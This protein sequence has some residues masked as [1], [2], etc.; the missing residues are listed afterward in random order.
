LVLNMADLGVC[1]IT[2]AARG[3]GAATARAAA[4]RGF[5]V[6]VNYRSAQS[7]AAAVVADIRQAGG[8]AHAFEADIR[9]EDDVARLFAAVDRAFGPVT[10]LVN[11]A[12]ISGV[13][14]AL[15]DTDPAVMRVVIETNLAGTLFCTR[16]AATRMARS[17]G[18][19]GGA[20]VSLSSIVTRTGG[21]RLATY[22]AT[23]AAIEG[24][25]KALAPELAEEGIR[26]NAVSPG[27]IATR[28]NPGPGD[29][30]RIPL[31]R[32]GTAEEVANAILWLLS[33]AAAY[34]TGATLEVGGGR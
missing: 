22:T 30:A 21:Y 7:D 5:A 6:A 18:G 3:I 11:N 29:P 28:Q 34:V 9:R 19:H 23:K 32:S 8:T 20:I 13:R 4:R 16:A 14:A 27:V 2:G 26:I 12:G 10:A 17:R 15:L 24:L 25:T 31:G 1:L 33:D